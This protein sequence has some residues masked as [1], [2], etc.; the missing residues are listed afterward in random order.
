MTTPDVG[1]LPEA[2]R[3]RAAADIAVQIVGRLANLIPGVAVTVMMTRALGA[4][5]F[6]QWS[7][8]LALSGLAGYFGAFGLEVAAVRKASEP[9]ATPGEWTSALLT[10]RLALAVPTTVACLIA[11]LLAANNAEMRVAGALISAT[12]P[13]SAV[14][15]SRV[16]LQLAM[17]NDVNVLALTLNTVIWTAAVVAIVASDGALSAYALALVVAAGATALFQAMA[18]NR[19]VGLRLR[20]S[21][22]RW[23]VLL[24]IGVP[25]G[26]TALVLAL[27]EW[28]DQVLVFALAG[29]RDAGLYGAVYRVLDQ[30][31]LIPSAMMTTLLPVMAAAGVPSRRVESL[32]QSVIEWLLIFSLPALAFSIVAAR[33][34]VRVLF[35]VE[36]TA[37]A[38]ALPVLISAFV[39]GSLGYLTGNLLTLMDRQ[40]KMIK[41]AVAGLVVNV[42]LNVFLI[43]RYGF[44]AAAAV[45]VATEA[46]VTG[47]A[48]RCVAKHIHVSVSRS[49]VL[50]AALA[51]TVTGA[52]VGAL[53]ELG[54][55][56]VGFAAAGLA[57]YVC[58]ALALRVIDLNDA[59]R[60]V[61]A[62]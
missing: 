40:G 23:R 36:Y 37:A 14:T 52:V 7:T 31:Q 8:A 43:P 50:G 42:C 33:P 57:T 28:V 34:T 17:R 60:W 27:T 22:R 47:L 54:A 46:L 6:G 10:L 53:R 49:R 1:P 62:R 35:G 21:P 61:G 11:E 41:Y 16:A 32:S 51:A 55:P 18:A 19:I 38:P 13:I 29:A 24:K 48:L 39:V 25:L 44:V 59:R 3:R 12:I 5:A 56:F 30:A 2:L 26:V 20:T 58:A 45:T 9:G 4:Q 15:S